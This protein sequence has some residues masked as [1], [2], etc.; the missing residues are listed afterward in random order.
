[1]K[2][3]ILTL[4]FV[5]FIG[6]TDAEFSQ[7]TALGSGGNIKCYSGGVLIYE[8]K[9]TGKISTESQSDGWYFKEDSKDGDLIRTNADCVIRN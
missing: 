8:G 9:A 4:A 2:T 3:I 5:S 6:C 7:L 1:M